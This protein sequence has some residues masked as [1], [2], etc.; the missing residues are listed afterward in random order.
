[1]AS[2]APLTSSTSSP[3][4]KPRRSSSKRQIF[5]RPQAKSSTGIAEQHGAVLDF[6]RIGFDVHRARR[7]HR[8]AGRNVEP[9][10]MQR[11]LD[12]LAIDE[13]VGE[14]RL[15]VR[16]GVMRRVNRAT[17]VVK[18]DRLIAERRAQSAVLG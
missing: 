2:S 6:H 12:V 1:M 10:L 13:A 18:A 15:S 11:A 7:T 16:A 5:M 14:A 3:S 8:L 4:T 9:P 17:H